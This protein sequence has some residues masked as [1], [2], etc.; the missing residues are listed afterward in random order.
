MHREEM[1]EQVR[2]SEFLLERC[3]EG[4]VSKASA[5]SSP[6][7]FLSSPPILLSVIAADSCVK[8]KTRPPSTDIMDVVPLRRAL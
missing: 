2:A 7:F 3:Q 4:L 6:P 8:G 1:G 5:P